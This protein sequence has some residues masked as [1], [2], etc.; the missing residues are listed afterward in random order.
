M[1]RMRTQCA[2]T[3]LRRAGLLLD[4]LARI[5]RAT[6]GGRL[7]VAGLVS[8]VGRNVF[9]KGSIFVTG[10]IAGPPLVASLENADIAPGIAL[11]YVTPIAWRTTRR[12]TNSERSMERKTLRSR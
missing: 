8:G 10:H 5:S 4:E 1:S 7:R 6:T 9:V 2:S 12:R 3:T 11:A